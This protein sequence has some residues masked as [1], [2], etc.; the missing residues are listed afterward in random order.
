MKTICPNEIASVTEKPWLDEQGW[1]LSDG[2]LHALSKEWSIE[3]WEAYLQSVEVGR[4]ETLVSPRQYEAALDRQGQ[5]V[6]AFAQ[7]HANDGLRGEMAALLKQLTPQQKKIIEM[8]FWQG[9][10]D[11]RVSKELGICRRT[12][13]TVKHRVLQ[14]LAQKIKK[15]SPS[16]RLVGGEMIPLI[17]KVGGR[18]AGEIRRMAE[19]KDQESV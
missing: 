1:P 11:A 15:M 8:T 19:G 6:F 18:G 9:L 4:V 12:V 17:R 13:R 16:Y 5:P 2:K 10:G 3:T 7:S 14:K